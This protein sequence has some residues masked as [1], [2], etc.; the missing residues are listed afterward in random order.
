MTLL[1][2]TSLP[3]KSHDAAVAVTIDI[4]HRPHPIER[5]GRREVGAHCEMLPLLHSAL[6][7]MRIARKVKNEARSPKARVETGHLTR[8]NETETDIEKGDLVTV[9]EGVCR[10]KTSRHKTIK[11]TCRVGYEEEMPDAPYYGYDVEAPPSP[12]HASGGYPPPGPVPPT[13]PMMQGPSGFTQHSN[14][15]TVNINPYAPHPPYNPQ[16]YPISNL[17]PPPP[18]PPPGPAPPGA[19]TRYGP[20]YVSHPRSGDNQSLPQT[21]RSIATEQ[22]ASP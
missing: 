22:G 4:G 11:L 1:K 13:G 7:S 14:Q 9:K 21:P 2:A 5:L 17:P 8:R 10:V 18:G 3:P 16:D 15:S 19:G 6:R 20:E 12:P